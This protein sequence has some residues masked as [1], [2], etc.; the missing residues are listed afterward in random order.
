MMSDSRW[1]L[2][3]REGA[4]RQPWPTRCSR[5]VAVRA[6]PKHASP[7]GVNVCLYFGYLPPGSSLATRTEMAGR[8]F[9]SRG[10]TESLEPVVQQPANLCRQK[11]SAQFVSIQQQRYS[12][13][14]LHAGLL[15]GPLFVSRRTIAYSSSHVVTYSSRLAIWRT[16]QFV[17]RT[18]DRSA[19][20]VT[21]TLH[22]SG[23]GGA[24]ALDR[25]VT[26]AHREERSSASGLST[27]PPMWLHTRRPTGAMTAVGS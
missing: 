26:G 12:T 7:R 6:R 16:R 17:S 15:H 20:P 1:A 9:A 5:R 10:R 19:A 4:R 25:L 13:R 23:R 3:R 18:H 14:L 2:A 11:A 21:S 8:Y 24:M 22:D 27:P